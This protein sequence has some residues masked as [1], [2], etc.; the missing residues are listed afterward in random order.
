MSTPRI[1]PSDSL[2]ELGLS[3]WAYC[4]VA[5]RVQGVPQMH[6]F[7]TLGKHKRLFWLWLP[8][9]GALLAG[10]LPKQDTELVILR[11]AHLRNCEYELHH[12]RR[13]AARRGIDRETQQKIFDWPDAQGLSPRQEALLAAADELV[14]TRT[15]GDDGWATLSSHLDRRQL[16]E[17]CMLVTQYDGVAATLSA[18]RVPSDD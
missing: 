1:S 12:H 16:I 17:F 14:T 8:Y 15:I 7:T 9:S 3:T 10:R 2:R 6:I 4:K 13:L 18:L 11:V 5:A